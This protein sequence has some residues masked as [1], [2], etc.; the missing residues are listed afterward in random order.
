MTRKQEL[1]SIVLFT[2]V[3]ALNAYIDIFHFDDV[4]V[5]WIIVD[6]LSFLIYI[7]CLVGFIKGRKK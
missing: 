5:G 6:S 3:I 7:W 1:I 4:H 2:I